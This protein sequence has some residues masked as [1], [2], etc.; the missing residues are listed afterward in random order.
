MPSRP[1]SSEIVELPRSA[2]L[3][4]FGRKFVVPGFTTA[5]DASTG[6]VVDDDS[7]GASPLGVGASRYAV[8][9]FPPSVSALT[10]VNAYG[11]LVSRVR[12]PSTSP[13]RDHSMPTHRASPEAKTPSGRP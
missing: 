11:T 3:T 1:P 12:G 10:A 13:G 5:S 8:A 7:P 9:G 6:S 2:G 4:Y